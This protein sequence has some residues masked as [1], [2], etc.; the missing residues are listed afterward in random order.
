MSTTL[1]FD[2]MERNADR[3][4]AVALWSRHVT[5]LVACVPWFG[6]LH[7]TLRWLLRSLAR[8]NHLGSLTDEQ[9]SELAA[10]L[11]EVHA[12]LTFLLDHRAMRSLKAK[13]LFSRFID[14]LE[15]DT[16]DLYDVIENLVFSNSR[17]FR[18]LLGDCVQHLST[19]DS[20]EPVGHL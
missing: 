8:G 15:E 19:S 20:L 14:S 10:K 12:Q 9:V 16:E 13:P 1:T 6:I 2:Q 7:T 4:L 3:T 11:R 5:G 17:E 18:S